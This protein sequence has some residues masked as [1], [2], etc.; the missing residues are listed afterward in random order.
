MWRGVKKA[1]HWKMVGFGLRSGPLATIILTSDIPQAQ[2]QAQAAAA[3][4]DL[5]E[6][7]SY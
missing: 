2:A 1:K 4:A 6:R 3:A 7:A 5:S